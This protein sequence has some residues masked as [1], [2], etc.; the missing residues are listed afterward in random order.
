MARIKM[1]TLSAGPDGVMEI[2]K[3]YSVDAKTAET[4]VK[5][6]FAVYIE[7]PKPTPKPKPKAKPKP[8][9]QATK[10]EPPEQAIK[11]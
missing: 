10:P 11:K 7:K 4:L 2:G 8:L 1:L 3:T 6:R 9:E 5:G